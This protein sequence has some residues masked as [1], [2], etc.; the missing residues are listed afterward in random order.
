MVEKKTE[1]IIAMVTKLN[2]VI[3]I[4][5][6]EWLLDFRMTIHVCNDKAIFSTYKEEVDGQSVLLGNHNAV[7]VHGK[8]SVELIERKLF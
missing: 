2:I 6:S 1:E 5:S 3:V 7:K 4:K 8:G